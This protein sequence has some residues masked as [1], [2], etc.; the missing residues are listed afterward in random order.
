MDA[1][2]TI[3]HW[4][5]RNDAIRLRADLRVCDWV[6]HL[7]TTN[8]IAPSS[9]QIY[10]RFCLEGNTRTERP[11]ERE[12][13]ATALFS[14]AQRSWAMRWR[15]RWRVSRSCIQVRDDIPLP[16]MQA[17]ANVRERPSNSNDGLL[18]GPDVARKG[19]RVAPEMD[20]EL[21]PFSG[22]LLG[23]GC[24]G[25]HRKWVHLLDPKMGT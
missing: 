20:P 8:G 6:S 9:S 24:Y 13:G 4:R 1:A 21:G 15:L 14:P 5:A 22:A 23:S 3:E 7:S 11:M 19:G 16:K 17:K 12:L 2:S 18:R 10:E 25:F